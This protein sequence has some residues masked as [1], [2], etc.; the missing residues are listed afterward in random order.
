LPVYRGD[1]FAYDFDAAL[2]AV[3]THKRSSPGDAGRSMRQACGRT[4]GNYAEQFWRSRLRSEGQP[5]QV[6]H[7]E[8][9][10]FEVPALP[11]TPR[12]LAR[13]AQ[14]YGSDGVEDYLAMLSK[15]ETSDSCAAIPVSMR[16]N[17]SRSSTPVVEVVSP[18]M[19][20]K[21]RNLGN[22]IVTLQKLGLGAMAIAD[23]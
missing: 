3:T 16:G 17:S 21:T 19:T 6:V 15:S 1:W 23:T 9:G 8:E 20:T 5:D 13:H 2:A 11:V 4:A 10:S 22:R 12:K 18:W 14:L 7:H